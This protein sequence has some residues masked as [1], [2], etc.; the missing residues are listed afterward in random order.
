MKIIMVLLF[1]L[2]IS[3]CAGVVPP[4]HVLMTNPNTGEWVYLQ[5]NGASWAAF[6]NQWS[7]INAMKMKGYTQMQ[8]VR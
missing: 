1:A 6:E 8:V 2:L 4:G 7:A 5:N 3:A